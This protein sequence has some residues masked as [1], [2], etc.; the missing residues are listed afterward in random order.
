[1]VSERTR[2]PRPRCGRAQASCAEPRSEHSL[3][4]ASR[5]S[6]IALVRRLVTV[7][8]FSAALGAGITT[9]AHA[10]IPIRDPNEGKATGMNMLERMAEFYATAV[11]WRDALIGRG[12]AMIEQTREL[13]R[14]REM[15]ERKMVGELGTLGGAVPDWREFAN[16]CGV[17]SGGGTVCEANTFLTQ[18]YEDVLASTVYTYASPLFDA[19]A[20]VDAT[21]MDAVGGRLGSGVDFIA[22]VAGTAHEAV[23]QSF[24]FLDTLAKSGA[25]LTSAGRGLNALIDS[26]LANQVTG[27]TLSSGRAQQLTAALAH[28]EALVEV[29]IVRTRL[30]GL[31]LSAVQTADNVAA[32]RV[33][34]RTN[35]MAGYSY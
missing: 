8:G 26:T 2:D 32:Y 34:K 29:E 12:R 1:M 20:T 28:A 14:V 18:R 3:R 7:V 22:D 17:T 25:D 19:I 9:T 11:E 6:G 15:W 35:A 13:V 27:Q 10:Q 33:S 5:L 31:E 30:R 24:A 4:V 16:F 21:A 23:S